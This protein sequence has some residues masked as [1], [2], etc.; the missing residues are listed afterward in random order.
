MLKILMHKWSILHCTHTHIYDI[1][2][3]W[4][5]DAALVS[6]YV[7]DRSTKRLLINGQ[8]PGLHIVT[9]HTVLSKCSFDLLRYNIHR[10]RD[11]TGSTFHKIQ[12]PPLLHLVF[13]GFIGYCGNG[14]D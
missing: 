9:T 6:D 10:Y 11:A 3:S 2:Y 5:A 7:K 1:C 14:S 8:L 4:A 12:P 13:I